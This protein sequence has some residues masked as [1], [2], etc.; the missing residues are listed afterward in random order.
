MPTSCRIRSLQDLK[1]WKK[2]RNVTRADYI[3]NDP[4]VDDLVEFLNKVVLIA[5][6]GQFD[7]DDK[8]P[9]YVGLTVD[10]YSGDRPKAAIAISQR[11]HETRNSILNR[12]DD[13]M[14]EWYLTHNHE[15]VKSIQETSGEEYDAGWEGNVWHL[16]A[17]ALDEALKRVDSNAFDQV[18][19]ERD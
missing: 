12:A 17:P 8:D 13:L 9:V 5:G 4:E 11:A 19:I 3:R 6:G 1:E 16:S 10:N 2:Q 14:R 7:L 15:F 18:E